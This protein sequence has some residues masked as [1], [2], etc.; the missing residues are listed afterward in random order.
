MSET[1][2]K[3]DKFDWKW[4]SWVRLKLV[5][6]KEKREKNCLLHFSKQRLLYINN[7][8]V[9]FFNCYVLSGSK[10]LF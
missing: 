2:P 5:D 6:G 8:F 9:S 3:S 1:D 4:N 10:N 7:I